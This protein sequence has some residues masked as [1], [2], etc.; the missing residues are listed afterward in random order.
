MTKDI[1]YFV[2]LNLKGNEIKEVIVENVTELPEGKAGKV[3]YLT[4]DSAENKAGYYYHNGTTWIQIGA[5][6]D[7]SSIDSRLLDVEAAIG[8][9]ET[10][11]STGI[12][13]RVSAL[14]TTVG[15]ADSGLVKAVADVT[16]SA[17]TNKTNIENLTGRVGTNETAITALQ[18]KDTAIEGRIAP[19]E[20][21]KTT[22]EA[23]IGNLKTTVGDTGSGLVKD[24]S[25]LQTTVGDADSG[26][27]KKVADLEAAADDYVVKVDGKQL[28]TEDYTT[29]E[30]T[31][32]GTIAEGAQVNVIESVKVTTAT[33]TTPLA[34]SDKAVT[35]DL[36]GYV[37]KSQIS[38]AMNYIDSVNSYAEL[39]G[40]G[41][42]KG[43]VYNVTAEFTID[44]KKY[45]AGTNVAWDGSTW[46][47]LGGTVDVSKFQTAEQ[48][49]TI[50]TGYGYLPKTEAAT[51]YVPQTRTV[52][53]KALSADITLA[54]ADVGLDKVDNT[55]DAD[56][57]ISTKT[58][59]ALDGKVD[60]L[61]SKPTAGTYTKVEIND[62]GQVVA[63]KDTM[64]RNADIESIESS[65]ITGF[66]T[67][68]KAAISKVGTVT[69]SLGADGAGGEATFAHGLGSNHPVVTVYSGARIIYADVSVVDENTIKIG[70]NIAGTFSV[71]VFVPGQ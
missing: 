55:A 57:P 70:S 31:K 22:A 43:D 62:E 28:S 24:V 18:N 2:N 5:Q 35:V 30:K 15:D 41:N 20:A 6:K 47:P 37:L 51:T 67:A 9:G 13:A 56:K 71:V 1:E 38:S 68:V 27:V 59:T 63:G 33:G 19:L 36:S 60:K 23:D 3:V 14:E 61:E 7:I 64:V 50:V 34:I 53:G 10:G 25:A 49:Q 12:G 29:A 58:Q 54:K 52:A 17:S 39:P 40:S 66:D 45:P 11:S 69:I 21:F 32:L 65:K 48:V 46:D 4:A 26:L 44:G 16:A 42:S 8:M